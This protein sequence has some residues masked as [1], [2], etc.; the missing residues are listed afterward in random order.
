MS[1]KKK[2]SPAK[3]RA[4]RRKK[5][6]SD[7]DAGTQPRPRLPLEA[8]LPAADSIIGEVPFTSPKGNRYLIIKTD[9]TDEYEE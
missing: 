7:A 6:V 9:E 1:S 5:P 3:K 2:S 8:G 4:V